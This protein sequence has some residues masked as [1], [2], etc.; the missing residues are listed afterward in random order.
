MVAPYNN[1]AETWTEAEET[2]YFTYKL[3]HSFN[4]PAKCIITL[5][6]PTGAMLR[7]YNAT[8]N[9]V[10]LGVGK[11]TLEDPTATDIFY[12]RI[13][14]A[15]AGT[16]HPRT[17]ILECYDWLDQLDE[18]II[19]YDMREDLNGSG[20]RQSEA[21]ADA[22]A[23]VYLVDAGVKTLYSAQA[24]DGGAFTDET[25]VANE[26]TDD[27][28][29]LMPALP[30]GNDAYYFGFETKVSGFSL[31]ISQQGDWVGT[32]LWEYWNG[33]S[34]VGL[35]N[36]PTGAD[37][38][39]ESA[40]QVDYTWTVQG[41]WA[42]V[43][44][45]GITTYW[46]R[47]RVL[48]F[49]AITTQPLGRQAW[50]E[51]YFYDDAMSWDTTPGNAQNF[52]DM[53]LVFTTG[54]AG[55]QTWRFYPYIGEHSAGSTYADH[56]YNTWHLDEN[57]DRVFQAAD[58]TL[59]YHFRCHL[60]HDTPSDF[61]VHSSITGARL[62]CEHL[63]AVTGSGNHAHI[64]FYDHDGAAFVAVGHLDE[65]DVR[66][67]QTHNITADYLPYIVGADGEAH[68]RYDL[69]RLGGS[70]DLFLWHLYLEL[71]V[72]T[73]PYSTLITI[74]ETEANRLRISTDLTAAATRV[75]E[76]IPYSILKPIHDHLESATG[77]ILGGD[78]V[79]TLTA[80]DGNIEDTTGYSS[81]Q[82]KDKTRLKILQFLAIEDASVFWITLGGT[83]VTYKKTFGADTMQLTD[84]SILDWQ[85]LYDYNTMINSVDVYGA[86][87]LNYEIYQQSQNAA[88]IL[89]FLN[90][91]SKVIRNAGLVTDADASAIGTAI[92]AK[93]SDVSQMVGCTI[94]GNT[95]TAGHAT[96]IKLGEIVEITSSYLWSTASKDY[97]VSRFVY[98]SN[99][100]KTYL[101]LYPKASTGERTIEFP[102]P[103]IE[104]MT[105][106]I[107]ADKYTPDPLTHEVG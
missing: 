100:N 11:I 90:T 80:A 13:K 39:F 58:C 82:F 95:A 68:V 76:A 54:M 25:I 92:A 101:T 20:L 91:K 94:H 49:T 106:K 64:Q 41:N 27:D 46:V 8:A 24:D 21:H 53:R 79:I 40:G 47:A 61:Y 62:V 7:K 103:T 34:W 67:E 51:Y 65:V 88:S 98:D 55:I 81:T 14:R 5:A 96:T 15:I 99:E 72:A 30:V 69:D 18:E 105:N 17:C 102:N 87:I 73:T 63:V 93:E 60:G 74:T 70:V 2:T 97:I 44:V 29:T 23:A 78:T 89:K 10:Y 9:A 6:D 22:D 45:N 36:G 59:D 48:S 32:M 71:D 31:H 107:E 43:A 52:D 86:R 3:E 57:Y 42:T 56:W 28:M 1:G 50:A 84:G 12:G 16:E 4:K 66:T 83:T 35:V 75:W 37:S 38:T 26:V 33:A 85:S 77:P 104:D 19:T